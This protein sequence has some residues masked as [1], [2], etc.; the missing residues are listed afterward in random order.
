MFLELATLLAAATTTETMRRRGLA[1]VLTPPR[2]WTVDN[3]L[4]WLTGAEEERLAAR[5]MAIDVWEPWSPPAIRTVNP[6]DR[7][8]G[9]E[10]ILRLPISW[11]VPE[12]MEL[13]SNWPMS[14]EKTMKDRGV[15]PRP[16][17]RPKGGIEHAAPSP[18][19]ADADLLP[20]GTIYF[21]PHFY[22]PG[23]DAE[24]KFPNG[25][26]LTEKGEVFP[27]P[28]T[29]R[30]K[31]DPHNDGK[32]P[33]YLDRPEPLFRFIPDSFSNRRPKGD[34]KKLR[35]DQWAAN[36]ASYAERR[37]RG[38]DGLTGFLPPVPVHRA[39]LNDYLDHYAYVLYLRDEPTPFDWRGADTLP[40]YAEGFGPTLDTARLRAEWPRY[41]LVPIQP[42][43]SI[44]QRQV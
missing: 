20:R 14:R 38:V 24:K 5:M 6:Q 22:H 40:E 8:G 37:N 30:Q 32:D 35:L 11:S 42:G 25:S 9:P 44:W 21:P 33:I 36:L 13:P 23:S 43:V 27:A 4:G 26:I 7:T 29:W 28:M 34:M 19:D 18:E 39:S 10:G 3:I 2:V 41:Y 12:Q 1:P 31:F 16:P 17:A 15:A